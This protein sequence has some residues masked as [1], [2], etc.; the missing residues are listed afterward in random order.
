MLLIANYIQTFPV[1]IDA[2]RFKY[3]GP[4]SLRFMHA[5]WFAKILQLFYV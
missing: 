3:E 1:N 4:I 2:M 5:H